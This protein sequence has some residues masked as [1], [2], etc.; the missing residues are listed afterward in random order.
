MKIAQ[1]VIRFWPA[2]GGGVQH[3]IHL[4][5][6]LSSRGH[7]VDVYTS[8]FID[9]INEANVPV[10]ER[11]CDRIRV[12]R[13]KWLKLVLGRDT[14][15]IAPKIFFDIARREYDIV[16]VHGFRYFPVYGGVF[17]SSFIK[18]PIVATLHHVPEPP[19]T[20]L[21]KLYD[22][23]FMRLINRFS[24][25][26]ALTN[27][28]RMWLIYHGVNPQKVVVIPNG[29]PSTYFKE[30]D[31]IKHE[32]V[33]IFRSKYGLE[34]I[35]CLTFLGRIDRVKNLDVIVKAIYLIPE[36]TRK[37]I[38]LLVVGPD[39]GYKQYLID[40]A[41]RLG[42]LKNILFLKPIT[43][44]REKM[45]L[46]RSSDIFIMPSIRETFSIASIEAMAARIPVLA[47]KVGGL[48]EVIRDG[49]S[50]YLL[51]PFNPNEW[52]EYI[53]KLVEDE[54]LRRKLGEN[55]RRIAEQYYNWNVLVTLIEQVYKEVTM[56]IKN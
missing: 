46:L 39:W 7:L 50:G 43:T 4:S 16:H 35:I 3:V 48:K 38:K 15:Y 33:L 12:R 28:E 18:T 42:V 44:E 56:N 53:I 51:D 26:I 24:K 2:I 34:N 19:N 49:I 54:Y 47:S 10:D 6:S 14:T 13:Y 21:Q 31:K 27:Y 36:N 41:K 20:H 40:L 23:V 1:V 45:I 37:N 30:I 17:A 22:A 52:A 25:I 11:Y 8:F 55:G 9:N 32:E 29:L 5:N